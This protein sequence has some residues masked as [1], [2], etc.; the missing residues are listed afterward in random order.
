M[1]KTMMTRI[2]LIMT[3]EKKTKLYSE[4][5][6]I[7]RTSRTKAVN[8]LDQHWRRNVCERYQ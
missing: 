1:A 6:L 4:E 7:W 8:W 2:K 3:V 5:M